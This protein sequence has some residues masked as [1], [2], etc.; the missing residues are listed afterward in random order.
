MNTVLLAVNGT[1]MRGLKLKKNLTDIGAI[2]VKE[3]TTDP[4]YKLWSINDE[5]P[6]MIRVKEDGANID[7]EIWQV[8]NEGLVSLLLNEP[9]GLSI[10]QVI[11]QDNSVVLGV[12]GEPILCENQLE[13]TKFKG[14]RSYINQNL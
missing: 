2:F 10:G 4:H 8:P 13:I 6:A 9:T 3:D 7:L 14:W 5:H 12:I 1:L 11:L